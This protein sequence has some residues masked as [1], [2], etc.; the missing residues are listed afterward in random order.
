MVQVEIEQIVSKYCTVKFVWV[1]IKDALNVS[2]IWGHIAYVI[3]A[4]ASKLFGSEALQRKITTQAR[5]EAQINSPINYVA[6]LAKLFV[7]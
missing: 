3:L 5:K 2:R 4:Y 7:T 1:R 6:L